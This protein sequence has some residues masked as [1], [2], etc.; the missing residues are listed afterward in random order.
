MQYQVV[1]QPSGWGKLWAAFGLAFAVLFI[2]VFGI[3][4]GLLSRTDNGMLTVGEVV[5]GI[6]ALLFV[7]ALGGKKLATPSF[8]G[9]KETWRIVK[10]IFIADAIIAVIDTISIVV[11]GTFELATLWPLRVLTLFIMCAG[12]GLFEE[13]TFRG[14]VFHGLLARM[15]VNRK[16]IFWAVIISS[17]IFG[18][19][20]IDPMSMNWADPSQVAQAILKIAQTG[21]FGF[22]AAAAVLKTGNLWP[23]VF[24]H[25]LNDFVLMFVSNGLMPTPVITTEY[26]AEGTE[27]L[28]AIGIYLVLCIAYAPSIVVAMRTIKELPVP[29]RGQ[30]YKA[31]TYDTYAIA[32]Q[33]VYA[34]PQAYYAAPQVYYAAPQAAYGSPQAYA[35]PQQVAYGAPPAYAVPQQAAYGTSPTYTVPQQAAYGA[36]SIY[37]AASQVPYSPQSTYEAPQPGNSTT[38]PN[39]Q[40]SL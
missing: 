8:A 40:E 7:L 31:R 16:G 20:H 25:G 35:V 4:L 14:L 2:Q 5:G 6:A 34:A 26:V 32:P 30:F 11:D 33:S 3:F 28:M 18:F 27:G 13:A 15:G 9:L 10:W 17:L 23:V 24:F 22:A 38:P 21:I 37:P 19:M 12:I 1:K 36:A 39:T 29:D